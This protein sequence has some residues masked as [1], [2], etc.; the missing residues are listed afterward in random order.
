MPTNFEFPRAWYLKIDWLIR[1][2]RS[3]CS[4]LGN[5]KLDEATSRALQTQD[6][7]LERV[8][9]N[10]I[11]PTFNNKIEISDFRTLKLWLS[12]PTLSRKLS[13]FSHAFVITRRRAYQS[14]FRRK[15]L[16][17]IAA[18]QQKQSQS[19]TSNCILA[20]NNNVTDVSVSPVLSFLYPVSI[21]VCRRDK[22]RIVPNSNWKLARRTDETFPRCLQTG[23]CYRRVD[24]KRCSRTAR[25]CCITST[26]VPI[27]V[28][29]RARRRTNKAAPIPRQFTSKWK[30]KVSCFFSMLF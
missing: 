9:R 10:I 16:I 11:K 18:R 17:L 6:F 19:W 24:V 7:L 30:V 3:A 20:T 5:K 21:L 26:E 29:T 15:N 14:I 27:T 28:H 4:F 12:F 1:T 22:Q 25:W 23:K 13:R 8:K 2:S